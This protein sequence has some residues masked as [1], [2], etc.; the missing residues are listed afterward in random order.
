[1]PQPWKGQVEDMGAGKKLD[2]SNHEEMEREICEMMRKSPVAMQ[3]V[4]DFLC[5]FTEGG[6]DED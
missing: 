4:Y 5:V 3:Y 6:G 2:G 1:M